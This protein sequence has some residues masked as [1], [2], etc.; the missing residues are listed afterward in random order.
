MRCSAVHTEEMR[1]VTTPRAGNPW[2]GSPSQ[3]GPSTSQ[4]RLRSAELDRLLLPAHT[5]LRV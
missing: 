5:L 1:P 3:T 2:R 4:E